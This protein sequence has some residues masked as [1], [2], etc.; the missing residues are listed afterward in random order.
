MSSR[1]SAEAEAGTTAARTDAGPASLLDRYLPAFQYREIHSIRITAPPERI[2][3]AI[4]ELTAGEIPLM[5]LLFWLRA[6]PAR[7]AGRRIRGFR[8]HLPFLAQA[9]APEGGFILLGETPERELVIGTAGE[10]WKILGG[11]Y[12]GIADPEDFLT[13]ATP[14]HARAALSFL[15]EADTGYSRLITETRVSTPG[16]AARR[17]FALYWVFVRPGSGLLRRLWLRAIKGR[18]ERAS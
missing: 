4:R 8:P 17:R 18:A 6:L 11:S 1:K 10:F 12:P 3:R 15:I 16:A 9:L 7:L 14:R 2:E 5:G 13:F